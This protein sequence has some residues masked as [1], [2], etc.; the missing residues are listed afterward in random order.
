MRGN[1]YDLSCFLCYE[2]SQ[3]S[4]IQD[5]SINAS[6]YSIC[7]GKKYLYPIAKIEI[8]YNN[9]LFSNDFS[10]LRNRFRVY[11]IFSAFYPAL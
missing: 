5:E 9:H 6:I 1:N 11:S 8:F 2:S 7:F 3:A 4:Y 10:L